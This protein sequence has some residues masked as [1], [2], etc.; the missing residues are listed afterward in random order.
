[1]KI[2]LVYIIGCLAIAFSCNKK[3][4]YSNNVEVI[5]ELT[6]NLSSS[7]ENYVISG[8][9][10][11]AIFHLVVLA[12]SS[13]RYDIK[14]DTAYPDR[15]VGAEIRLGDPVSEGGLLLNLPVRVYGTYASGVLTGVAPSVIETLLNN[16]IDKYI[17]VITDRAANGLVRGQLNSDLVFSKNV[18][19]T[20]TSVVPS[21]TTTTNGT[22]FLRLTS[23]NVLYSKVVV[24]N[25]DPADPVATATIN[26]GAATANGAAILTLASS[27]QEFGVGKKSTISAAVNSALL[28]N[29]TYVTVN[30]TLNPN[31]KLR[32][33]IR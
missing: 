15:I 10:T 8:A 27:P 30:S 3:N 2:Y 18:P 16:N 33:Q 6:F 19:L 20:G 4:D 31:G 22:T 29:S 23:N 26:Q 7:N 32:G 11:T 25:N 28:S 5:K 13:M 12:D 24:N 14:G 17:N 21:V 1:M 9:P